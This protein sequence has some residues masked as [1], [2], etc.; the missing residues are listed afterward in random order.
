LTVAE[1]L[2]E[3]GQRE[4]GIE[5]MRRARNLVPKGSDTL[6]GSATQ[7]ASIVRVLIP[8]RELDEAL[9]ELD[10]YLAGRGQWSIEGLSADPRL[11][12]IRDDSRFA[13]LVAK[14]ERR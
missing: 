6:S 3:S 11:D 9:S 13:T 10:D 4:R 1:A 8:A 14:Y 12:P 2:V 7:L 5:W